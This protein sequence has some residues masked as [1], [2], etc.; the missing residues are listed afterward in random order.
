[1]RK[2]SL[3]FI[4]FLGILLFFGVLLSIILVGKIA[5]KKNMHKNYS[6]TVRYVPL[7]DSYTIGEG[8]E[9]KER[10]PNL[11][12]EHLEKDGIATE[13]IANPSQSGWTTEEVYDWQVPILTTAKP[14]FVT[15]LVGANDIVQEKEQENFQIDFARLIDAI[16]QK[17]DAQRILILT[18]PDFSMSPKGKYLSNVSEISLEIVAFNKII[19]TEAAKRKIQI[20][21]IHSVSR[22]LGTDKKYFVQDGLHP[23]L[24]QYQHWE[25]AV[26]AAA[27][28]ILHK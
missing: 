14:T 13:L 26:Y 18:I 23:S 8:V 9:E 12:V 7:G 22:Q 25:E 5:S 6:G 16:L 24:L 1:M 27:S 15:L 11:L 10:W 20:V 19:K 3:L 2:S 4:I 28:E 21:D 17:V